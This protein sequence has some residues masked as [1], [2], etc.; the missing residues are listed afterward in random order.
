[1][2]GWGTRWADKWGSVSSVIRQQKIAVMVLQE[3]HPGDEIRETIEK[4]FRNTLYVLHSADPVNPTTTGGVSVIINKS[5]VGARKVMHRTVVD[6]HMIMIEIPR[7]EEDSLR[8]MNVYAPVRNAEKAQFWEELLEKV[9]NK[10]D[11]RPDIMLGDFNLVE[12]PEIDRLNNR[13]G[14]DPMVARNA[15]SSFTT[16]LNLADGWR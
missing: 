14:M 7:N 6:G 4:R 9:E 15:L 2:N 3:T 13:Q 8:V 5:L 10:E 1:M 16:E 12:N 11:L